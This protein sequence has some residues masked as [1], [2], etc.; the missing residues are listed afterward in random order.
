MVLE[1]SLARWRTDAEG[2][3]FYWRGGQEWRPVARTARHICASRA[4]SCLLQQGIKQGTACE[5]TG[6]TTISFAA[7]SGRST[8]AALQFL[9]DD[10]PQNLCRNAGARRPAL[11]E[12]AA[13]GVACRSVALPAWST[14]RSVTCRMNRLSVQCACCFTTC[15]FP[16]ASQAARPSGNMQPNAPAAAAQNT[17]SACLRRPI[18]ENSTK[19]ALVCG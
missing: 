5:C 10:V 19:L 3:V 18:T 17:Q 6:V 12:P 11:P 9:I 16:A 4:R 2:D 8:Q 14:A 1:T 15:Q 13:A 7:G